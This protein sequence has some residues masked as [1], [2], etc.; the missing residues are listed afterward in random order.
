[1][2]LWQMKTI[3]WCEVVL[4]MFLSSVGLCLAYGMRFLESLGCSAATILGF[5]TL[6]LLGWM[7]DQFKRIMIE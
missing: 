6:V 1:M 7:V 5:G 4:L 3:F 2:K